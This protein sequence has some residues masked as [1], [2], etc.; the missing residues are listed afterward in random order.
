MAR[1]AAAGA[2]LGRVPLLPAEVA[3]ARRS[4]LGG[5]VA[6]LDYG[7][8]PDA[9]LLVG[10]HGL[11]GAAWNWA[12]LAP[13]LTDQVRLVALDLAG[14]GLTRSA[15]RPTT[16]AANR[17]LLDRWLRGVIGQ[18]AILVGN[19]MGGAISLLEGAIAPDCVR[20]LVLI[21][22]ALP[23]PTF[24]RIDPQVALNFAVA[25]IPWVGQTVAARRARRVGVERQVRDTLKL[26]TVDIDRIPAW[27]I[28]AGVDYARAR[29]Q[30]PASVPDFLAAARSVVALLSRPGPLRR[31]GAA[32][33]AAG[34]PVLLLHG[35]SDR[36]VPVD[37][38]RRF[39]RRHPDWRLEVIPDIGHVPMLE[40]PDWTAEQILSWLPGVPPG[41]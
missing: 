8:P 23:R 39:A 30:D 34:I 9:P 21:D 4:D 1:P 26:C 7:G 41:H 5:E 20:G 17:R 40:A 22:P 11:G 6:W 19:S 31:A 29:G 13:L 38:A 24:S 10:V 27:I 25:S 12:V 36:L 3:T 18:P 2:M 37:V 28:D 32:V 16:V 14:H 35:E 15:G 33:D